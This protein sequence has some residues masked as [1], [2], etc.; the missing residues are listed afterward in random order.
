M[1]ISTMNFKGGVGK[2]TVCTNLAVGFILEGKKVCLVDTDES[3]AATKWVGRR[4][5]QGIVPSIASVQLTDARTLVVALQ[6]LVQDN[7]VVLVDAPPRLNPLISKIILLSDL[8]IVPVP[9][10][11]GNDR[12]VTE[13]FLQRF[14]AIQ[15][16][17]VDGGFTPLYLLLN[18]VKEG[19]NLHQAFMQSLPEL[20][21][22]YQVKQF[23]N[24]LSDLVAFGE[25]NQMGSGV[26][27]YGSDKAKKEFEQLFKEIQHI[28]GDEK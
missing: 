1:L 27:E 14:E 25:S 28:L 12:E 5:E 21:E 22:Q 11:S 7:D 20:C 16:Q 2:T 17:R 10:K 9:P 24:K 23:T 13:D 6:Q 15:E 4:A 19:Y 26:L 18:M 3:F 8:V